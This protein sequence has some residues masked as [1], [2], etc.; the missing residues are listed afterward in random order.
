MHLHSLQLAPLL[1]LG[2]AQ[3]PAENLDRRPVETPFQTLEGGVIVVPVV[4][5]GTK[6]QFILDTGIGVSLINAS[7]CETFACTPA[8]AYT[9]QRM[10]GQSIEVPLARIASLSFGGVTV[11]D[12]TVGVVDNPELF[13]SEAI[14][15]YL[16]LGHFSSSAVTISFSRDTIVN[17]SPS[18]L[19]RRVAAGKSVA[20]KVDDDGT[21]VTVAVPIQ[22]PNGA[23]AHAEVDTGSSALILDDRFLEPL[24]IDASA[25]SVTR[26]E[27]QDETGHTFVR[28]FVTMAGPFSP[29][30]T[31][32]EVRDQRVMFQDII[33]EGLVGT[34]FLE[35]FDVT[36]DLAHARMIFVD[37]AKKQAATAPSSA[38]D[39]P[40]GCAA[41]SAP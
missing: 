41:C 38:L 6:T 16:S 34:S 37:V 29:A 26:R 4:A 31:G 13:P 40:Q 3:L 17:E 10:S 15:G 8:G 21:S 9:G 2:C 5:A 24:S 32:L 20:V 19:A 36:F 27:G 30:G 12:A 18:S 39:D 1:L 22:L 28:L 35:R 11:K 33:H 14:T 25:P 23:V 7:L